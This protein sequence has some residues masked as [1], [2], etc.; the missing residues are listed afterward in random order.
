MDVRR[1]VVRSRAEVEVEL[2]GNRWAGGWAS[3]Y[4]IGPFQEHRVALK[5]YILWTLLYHILYEKY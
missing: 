5:G 3:H 1:K 4:T 2:L